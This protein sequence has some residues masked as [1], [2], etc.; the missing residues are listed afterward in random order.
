MTPIA[1]RVF[2]EEICNAAQLGTLMRAQFLN[3]V[4]NEETK[5]RVD[6]WLFLQ[7]ALTQLGIVSKFLFPVSRAGKTALDRGA[8]LRE[9]LE[10]PAESAINN[11]DARDSLEHF[12]ERL[13]AIVQRKDAGILQIVVDRREGYE[14]FNP[15]RWVFRRLYIVEEDVLVIQNGSVAQIA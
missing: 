8:I 2:L 10:V 14:F 13:D 5:Q 15:E 1:K 12:D 6:V 11:R 7:G 4:R 3:F 9:E